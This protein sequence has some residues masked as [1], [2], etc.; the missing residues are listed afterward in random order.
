MTLSLRATIKHFETRIAEAVK[1]LIMIGIGIQIMIAQT[2]DFNA[3]KMLERVVNESDLAFF[4]ISVGLLRLAALSANGNWPKYGPWLRAVGAFI[5]S[6]IWSN[7]FLSLALLPQ[8]EP[9]SV[10]APIFFVFSIVEI[11]SVYRAIVTRDRYGR[12]V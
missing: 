10:A 12:S 11:L 5:G 4:F 9:R 2:L 6:L 3:L 1:A 7:M 8:T